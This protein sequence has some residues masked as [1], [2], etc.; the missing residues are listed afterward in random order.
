MWKFGFGSRCLERIP[1]LPLPSCVD[2]GDLRG[3][4]FPC[5]VLFFQNGDSEPYLEG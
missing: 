1:V 3:L 4:S 5:L 2:S